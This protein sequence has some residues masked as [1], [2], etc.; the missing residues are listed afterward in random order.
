MSVL[1]LDGITKSFGAIHALNGVDL[2]VARGEA[3]G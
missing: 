3:S 2:T 1:Q